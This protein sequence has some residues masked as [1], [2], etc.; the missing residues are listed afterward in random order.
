MPAYKLDYMTYTSAGANPDHVY[1]YSKNDMWN[2][3]NLTTNY[4]KTF[5]DVHNAKLLLG[6]SRVAY[7]NAYNWSQITQLIDYS[8][9][10]FDLATGNQTTSGGED[11]SHAGV[12][13]SYQLRLQGEIPTGGQPAV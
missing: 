6:M 13:R 3:L 4:V 10:Q 9:P 12:L 5:A 2:T 7:E 1:R 11:W 8:N